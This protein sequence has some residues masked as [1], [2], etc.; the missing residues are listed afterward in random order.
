M[1]RTMTIIQGFL[2]LVVL[3]F[4]SS[5]LFAQNK[6][7]YSVSMVKP[8]IDMYN[9]FETS[10][11]LHVSKFHKGDNKIM[12]NE[13]LSGPYSGYYEFVHGP[14]TFAD[15][16]KERADKSAHDL[17]WEKTCATKLAVET[18]NN[19]Y[20]FLDTLSFN[21]DV[22]VEKYMVTVTQVKPGK[23]GEYQAEVRRGV[24][25]APIMNN[26]FSINRYVQ[27]WSGTDPVL[28]TLNRLKDGFKQMEAN[29]FGPPPSPNFQETYIKQ[30][31]QEQWDKR[32]KFL[33]E[34]IVQSTVFLKKYRKDLSSE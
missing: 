24:K 7:I 25:L 32:L 17:D 27:L 29:Y 19:Y 34:N 5:S 10:W 21:G 9:A 3:A 13:I 2:I 4:A 28:V 20:R 8:K 18:P 23:M 15:M 1:K 22:K 33:D 30:Y 12:V 31:G 11:K 16:D 26:P 6:N 14:M